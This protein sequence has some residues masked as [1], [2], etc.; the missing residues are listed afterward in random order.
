MSKK[1]APP[2]GNAIREKITFNR[3]YLYLIAF[4]EGGSVMAIE[5][6]GARMIAP[7]FGTS[8]YVWAS[9]LAV[10][11]GGLAAGYFAGGW[12]T[13][14]FPPVKILFW[15]LL[16]GTLL[17]AI[18]PFLAVKFMS[19]TGNL[20]LRVGS[21]FSSLS[22]MFLPLF[23]LGMISPTIIQLQSNELKGTG[24][25]AGTIYAIST[26]GGILMT[27]LMGFYL[28]PD[29]GIRK[30]V[31]LSAILLGIM[32]IL[33]VIIGRKNKAE[34]VIGIFILIILSAAS[35]KSFSDVKVSSLK[36]LYWSEGILGQLTVAE[37]KSGEHIRSLFINQIPQT[38]VNPDKLPASL[39]KYPHRLAMIASIKPENSKALLI[40]LGGG[41][42]AM[43]LKNMGFRV[44]AVE[45]DKR[46]QGVAEKYFGFEPDGVNVYVDD[47]RHYIRTA[48][49]KYD[50]VIIDVLNGEI[51]PYHMFTMESFAEMKQ[52][53]EPDGLLIIN[54]QG[55]L[56]G[57][58]GLGARSIFKTLEES[59]FKVRYYFAGDA[60]HSGDIHF[61]ASPADFEMF[62]S[63]S[64]KINECCIN[65]PVDYHALAISIDILS[66]ENKL[67]LRDAET[68]TDDKPAL[69]T[70]YNYSFEEWRSK[71]LQNMLTNLDA[72]QITLFR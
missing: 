25:T 11:L 54:N 69:T 27:L 20:G 1:T 45:L 41:S 40:G 2:P 29:W 72:E 51:Q 53:L 16:A 33:V 50:L 59:G 6:T 24:K 42:L 31:L 61:I 70:L 58:K 64:E 43:E 15:E 21:L 13:Y 34:A 62:F 19:L 48:E 38:Y 32:A 55:F 68:L 56:L 7:F 49:K 14:R 4:I 9:V 3:K 35:V 23:C 60:D 12:A 26:I 39:W 46:V 18:M 52:I 44:D 37:T 17:I 66:D 47:G 28:L 57:E 8:L 67:D 65:F 71:A 22:F 30:S 63:P 5:L 10:T 36:N